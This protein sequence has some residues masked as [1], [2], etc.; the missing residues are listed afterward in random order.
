MSTALLP[1]VVS[2]MPTPDAPK[3]TPPAAVPRAVRR[4]LRK[5]ADLGPTLDPIRQQGRDSEHH[6]RPLEWFATPQGCDRSRAANRQR[7]YH[8]SYATS[9]GHTF[10]HHYD[11]VSRLAAE[12]EDAGI[13]LGWG[14]C[15]GAGTERVRGSVEAETGR[16]YF[17]P[18]PNAFRIGLLRNKK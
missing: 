10:D 4:K 14:G 7:L 17:D 1:G 15:S 6:Y 5:Q 9:S 11:E 18:R 3:P 12:F 2:A 8:E 16:R 13:N